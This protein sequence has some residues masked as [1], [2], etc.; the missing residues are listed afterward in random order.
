MKLLPAPTVHTAP[1]P[2]LTCE[3]A[4]PEPALAHLRGLFEAELDWQVRDGDAYQVTLADA[5]HLLDPAL[6]RA[7]VARVSA[8]LGL[9]LTDRVALTV[10]RMVPGQRVF[11]HTDQ[12]WL[13]F[14]AARLLIYLTPGWEPA[15]GGELQVH[16]G[17][18]GP[19]VASHAPRFNSAVAFAMS[20]SSFHSVAEARA[21]RAVA[22]FNLWHPQNSPRVERA[23]R[24]ALAPLDLRQLPQAL[25]PVA[26]E[27]ES[28]LPEE[29]T[30]R[31]ASAA[32]LLHRW[33]ADE[34]RV[35]ASY[36]RD[37]ADQPAA[38]P[39]ERLA[40]WAVRV[41]QEGFDGAC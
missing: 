21:P 18:D 24:E 7:V 19:P 11:V 1:F 31:A 33:G 6:A 37:L 38:S 9:P 15:H 28:R 20:R 34:G 26:A 5:S 30:L 4:L 27:A 36:L 22:I 8:L 13:G 10:Q 2:F 41:E 14:E 3:E 23:I 17:L 39:A 35:I 12:P 16:T 29:R 32:W 25:D 40:R